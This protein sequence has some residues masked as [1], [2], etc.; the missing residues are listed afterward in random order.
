MAISTL[1]FTT[2][3][4][5][6]LIALLTLAILIPGIKMR[7]GTAYL[8]CSFFQAVAAYIGVPM[9]NGLNIPFV[10][11]TLW[12]FQYTA[13]LAILYAAATLT[14]KVEFKTSSSLHLGALTL[15]WVNWMVGI[16]CNLALWV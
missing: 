9:L 11:L 15:C 6:N 16:L 13:A 14:S 7:N 2:M 4:F 12:A 8:G 1:L 10:P 3:W 5:L